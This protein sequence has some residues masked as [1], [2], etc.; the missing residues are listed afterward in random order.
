MSR[1]L[2]REGGS[3]HASVVSQQGKLP[4]PSVHASVVSQQGNSLYRLHFVRVAFLR[5]FFL[6]LSS[7][8]EISPSFKND[9]LSG[10]CGDLSEP[11]YHCFVALSSPGLGVSSA[12]D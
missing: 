7:E 12:D 9:G 5:F 2:A 11:Q 8:L 1:H 4:V 3:V 6:M 10:L